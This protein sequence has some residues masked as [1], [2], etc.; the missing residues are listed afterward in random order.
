MR[1]R[2]EKENGPFIIVFG[3]GHGLA[4]EI[5]ERSDV[6]LEPIGSPTE[7]NHLSV[8]SAVAISLDRLLGDY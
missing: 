3:T 7:W 1:Q 5:L 6:V 2:F 8:R 4:D